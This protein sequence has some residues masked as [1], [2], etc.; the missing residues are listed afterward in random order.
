MISNYS[1]FLKWCKWSR[2]ALFLLIFNL[3]LL[4]C[5]RKTKKY[6]I[7][8]KVETTDK[9]LLRANTNTVDKSTLYRQEGHHFL[10]QHHLLEIPRNYKTDLV[11]EVQRKYVRRAL[12]IWSM[13]ISTNFLK[14]FSIILS[15]WIGLNSLMGKI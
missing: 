8:F 2:M 12:P 15:D 7:K 11:Y 14:K 1:S 6:F 9:V 3:Y 4:Y 10:Q 5:K 13:R